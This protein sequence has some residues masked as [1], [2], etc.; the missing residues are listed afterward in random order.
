MTAALELTLRLKG[1]RDQQDQLTRGME[2]GPLCV[3]IVIVLQ[4]PVARH[5][6][7]SMTIDSLFVRLRLYFKMF[8]IGTFS[9]DISAEIGHH[10][11]F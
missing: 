9:L 8:T 2:P 7:T 6:F 3:L 11:V 5:L 4:H 10:Q 1:S